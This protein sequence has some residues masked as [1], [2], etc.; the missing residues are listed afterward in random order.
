MP[1]KLN[2]AGVKAKPGQS[3]YRSQTPKAAP[4]AKDRAPVT[5]LT[6]TSEVPTAAAPSAAAVATPKRPPGLKAGLDMGSKSI[7]K[8]KPKRDVAENKPTLDTEEDFAWGKGGGWTVEKWTESLDLHTLIASALN[9]PDDS[10]YEYTKKLSKEQI[11]E[12]LRHPALVDALIDEIVR[13]VSKLEQQAAA[14]GADLNKKFHMDGGGFEMAFGS[15]DQFFRGLEGV[16]GP[17]QMIDGSLHKA[18]KAEHTNY[19]D[20]NKEFKSAN[21]VT[22]TSA[23]EWEFTAEPDMERAHDGSSATPYPDRP[24]FVSAG[25]ASDEARRAA[26]EAGEEF[27]ETGVD[28]RRKPIAIENFEGS[29]EAVNEK[30][31][32]AGHNE[33]ILVEA[34][35]GRL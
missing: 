32:K 27:V 31:R 15:L 14:T 18:M 35:A 11:T 33:L 13:G 7:R 23:I 25:K 3:S 1:P 20:A 17:P 19:K 16:I 24:H 21:G 22:T 9:V 10:P 12:R 29:I 34:L 4:P 6:S 30:L 26:E 2:T 28:M 8:P 5:K